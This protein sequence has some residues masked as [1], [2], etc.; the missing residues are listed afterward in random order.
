MGGLGHPADRISS[1]AAAGFPPPFTLAC[2]IGGIA[3]KRC[4]T[5]FVARQHEAGPNQRKEP[6]RS[7]PYS[8]FRLLSVARSDLC[9]YY[10][11]ALSIAP[12]GFP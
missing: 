12:K 9:A 3:D 4:Q 6:N 8:T 11:L 2:L 5:P 7:I 10:G 1:R